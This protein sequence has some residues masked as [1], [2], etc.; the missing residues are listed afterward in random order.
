MQIRARSA[1]LPVF[2]GLILALA[3]CQPDP[4]QP[5]FS[6]Y[7]PRDQAFRDRFGTLG[8]GDGVTLFSNRRPEDQAGSGGGGI[9]VNAYL[10][11][12]ALET[13]DFMPLVSA[14]PFGGLIITDWY[15][16]ATAPDER[17]RLQ[18]LI[19]DA[20]LRADGVKV[21]VLRQ[22]RNGAGDWLDM[23]ADQQTATIIEDKILTRARELRV[24]G[25]PT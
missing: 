1:S 7:D 18:V 14:D 2:L 22:V 17:L 24:A 5:E 23:P 20:A 15:Q 6:G 3:A 16:P 11:R 4:V 10:W 9:G 19:R 12:G 21:A 13:I 25:L 8:G